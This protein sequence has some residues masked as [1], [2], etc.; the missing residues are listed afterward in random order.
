MVTTSYSYELDPALNVWI[1]VEFTRT[2]RQIT[3]YAVVLVVVHEPGRTETIRLYDAAH[4]VNERHRYTRQDGKQPAEIFHHGT[5]T[6][7]L[8]AA[9]KTIQNGYH[10]MVESWY[11]K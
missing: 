10:Q 6:E 9:I 1:T 11:H 5:L 3:S 8:Q 7:G 4:G 2:Q